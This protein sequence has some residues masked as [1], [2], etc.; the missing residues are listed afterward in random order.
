MTGS[1]NHAKGRGRGR[2][3]REEGLAWEIMAS[4]GVRE[5][6]DVRLRRQDRTRVGC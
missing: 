2:P 6:G 3:S 5:E 4:G 1:K